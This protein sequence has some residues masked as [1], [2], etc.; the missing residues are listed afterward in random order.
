MCVIICVL[1]DVFCGSN[2]CTALSNLLVEHLLTLEST[3]QGPFVVPQMF[4]N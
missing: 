2:K 1:V 4:I 3:C